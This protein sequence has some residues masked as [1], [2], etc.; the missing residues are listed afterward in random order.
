[1]RRAI[2]TLVD[3]ARRAWLDPGNDPEPRAPRG[4]GA[5]TADVLPAVLDD[6]LENLVLPGLDAVLSR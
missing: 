1:V 4:H 2:P 3:L 5:L 6:A